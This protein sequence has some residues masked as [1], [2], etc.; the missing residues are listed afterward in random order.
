MS[1]VAHASLDHYERLIEAGFFE[2]EFRRR[3]ELIR[4]E[5]LDMSPIG[6]SHSEIVDRLAA[7][8]FRASADRPIRI[9]V[10]NPVR[11]PAND[12]EPEPDIAWVVDGS[13]AR[14]HPQPED[15]LLLIEVAENSL[16]FDRRTK[17]AVYAEAGIAEYWIVNLLDEQIEA[18]QD[19]EGLLYRK[20]SIYRGDDAVSP[21]AAPSA[22]LVPSQLFLL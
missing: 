14:R 19:P 11:I 10:Q 16:P 22:L 20:K 21:L 5:I 15:V 2:G 18:Y 6:S 4:G 17:L 12:S 13:Y 1:T 3:V 8:S 7:W 9:R